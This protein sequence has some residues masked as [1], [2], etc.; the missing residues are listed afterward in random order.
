MTHKKAARAICQVEAGKRNVRIDIAELDD[1]E[2]VLIMSDLGDYF[3]GFSN[4][5]TFIVRKPEA[6]S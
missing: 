1:T 5:N 6:K 3:G 2:S 4:G